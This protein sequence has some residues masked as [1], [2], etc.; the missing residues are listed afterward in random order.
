MKIILYDNKIMLYN[1]ELYYRDIYNRYGIFIV[2]F[3]DEM[4]FYN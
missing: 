4:L 3:L 1:I 2:W